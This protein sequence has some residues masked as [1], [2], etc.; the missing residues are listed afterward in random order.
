MDQ[1]G[2]VVA[3]FH[4]IHLRYGSVVTISRNEYEGKIGGNVL[5]PVELYSRLLRMRIMGF[6]PYENDK[7]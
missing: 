6:G 2:G 5:S 7:K 3:F 4:L 1:V